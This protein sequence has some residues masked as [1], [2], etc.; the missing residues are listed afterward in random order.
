MQK[1]SQSWYPADIIQTL[2]HLPASKLSAV[3]ILDVC[4]STNDYLLSRELPPKAQF[5]LCVAIRQSA[6]RGRFAKTWSS[7]HSGIYL[8]VSWQVGSKITRDGWLLLMTA[9]RLAENLNALG[10]SGIG[11]KWPNDL[12]YQGA[13]LAGMLLEH[14]GNLAVMGIGLNIA[15]PSDEMK[16]SNAN[17]IGL[18]QSD[19]VVPTYSELVALVVEAALAINEEIDVA[20]GEQRFA[21]LDILYNRAVEIDNEGT[22]ISGV[23]RGIDEKARL[24]VDRN[25]QVDAYNYGEIS[26]RNDRITDRCRQ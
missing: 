26:I 16:E 3:S 22:K 9:V 8:S 23:A 25:G 24:L 19:I 17:W 7:A 2:R 20:E 4:S 21:N 12:Y 6:G 1:V 18:D 15:T 5:N 11:V 10:I 14:S 13:K